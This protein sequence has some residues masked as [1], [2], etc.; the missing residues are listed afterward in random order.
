[1]P[2]QSLLHFATLLVL[3]CTCNVNYLQGNFLRFFLILQFLSSVEGEMTLS[4]PFAN[5]EKFFVILMF[6]FET[7][8]EDC[9]HGRGTL[10]RTFQHTDEEHSEQMD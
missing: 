6:L 10:T 8:K 7:L 3:H 9:M 2:K 1:M 4:W 5:S